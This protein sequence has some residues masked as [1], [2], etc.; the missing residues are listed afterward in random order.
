MANIIP[1]LNLNKTPNLV[2]ANSLIFAKNIRL[3][4]D[5]SIHRDYGIFPLSIAYGTVSDTTKVNYNN[6]LNRIRQD[7]ISAERLP[8]I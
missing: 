2:E 3:D 5:G 6:I 7:I 4:N 8:P 1:K